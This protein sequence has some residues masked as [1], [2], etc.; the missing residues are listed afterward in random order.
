VRI[1]E[2]PPTWRVQPYTIA[3]VLVDRELTPE[4]LIGTHEWACRE[5][6]PNPRVITPSVLRWSELFN[7]RFFK[8]TM[9]DPA[10]PA[11]A[12]VSRL[13]WSN[14][15][16]G[17][18]DLT[19]FW[20]ESVL[21]LAG[22]TLSAAI[23][24]SRYSAGTIGSKFD[25]LWEAGVLAES[26]VVSDLQPLALKDAVRT[27]AATRGP[28]D[29]ERL[30]AIRRLF[31]ASL[32]RIAPDDGEV[33]AMAAGSLPST[34]ADRFGFVEMLRTACGPRLRALIVY[35]S[36]VASESFA[37]YDLLLIVDDVED[38][39][40]AF[41]GR[42]PSWRGRELN[43]GVYSPDEMLVMQ[44]LSGD[45]IGEYGLCLW[46]QAAVVRKPARM[47]LARNFSFGVVRQRQQLGML[48]RAI[49]DPPPG[50]GDDRRNLYEYFVKIPAN[51]AKGTFGV[52][53]SRLSKEEIQMWLQTCVGFDVAAQQSRSRAGHHVPALANAAIAT[54]V[55]LE[56]LNTRVEMCGPRLDQTA[57]RD[58]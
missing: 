33:V 19:R 26:G 14:P 2:R 31:M 54:G 10:F 12:D 15:A 52:L 55:V 38:V 20:L 35:G 42:S 9:A 6:L 56:R 3:Y 29:V 13:T 5:G 39:L 30:L 28:G 47:L 1:V 23:V 22:V 43:L 4:E 7:P 17:H 32:A 40:R 49:A 41:A 18:L 58:R 24:Q 16:L 44:R 37:D 50:D 27:L 51:V 21:F 11:A 45:N 8:A 53:G 34:M 48:S 46:G 57:V 36:S 25:R